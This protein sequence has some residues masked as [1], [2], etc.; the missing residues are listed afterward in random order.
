MTDSTDSIRFARLNDVNYAEWKMRTEAV[1]TR[2][3]LWLGIIHVVLS[4]S[5]TNNKSESEIAALLQTKLAARSA[6]KLAE[7]R[8]E[9]ILRVEDGQLAY[10]HDED[11]REIWYQ[12][13]RVHQARGFATKLALKRAF[14][15]GKMAPAQSMQ[16]WIGQVSAHV[17]RMEQ[18]G[19]KV[20]ELDRI[21]AITMGL[22]ASYTPVIIHFDS[23]PADDLTLNGV[24]SRLLNEEIRQT[25]DA[26]LQP[27]T[28]PAPD[29]KLEED[30]AMAV[31][32]GRS[33]FAMNPAHVTCFLCQESG[34][35]MAACPLRGAFSAF[36]KKT[37]ASGTAAVAVED[38]GIGDAYSVLSGDE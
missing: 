14:L 38:D 22:P 25:A 18:A 2:R 23:L 6:E 36:L 37:M 32:G 26:A 30:I 5:E 24:I 21:L 1:L 17:F 35:F 3:G 20:D 34:H 13:Q 16:A 7:A 31:T 12:L 29:V 4:A 11:P 28:V 19:I 9:L 8:A 15:T 33:K 10:M 27:A